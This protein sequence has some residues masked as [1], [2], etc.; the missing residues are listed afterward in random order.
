MFKKQGWHLLSL[1][2]SLVILSLLVDDQLLFGQ[3]W[4]I[5]TGTWFWVAVAVPIVH[6]IVVP[7][8]WRAE[9]YHRWMTKTFGENGF[10]IYKII[11]TI[12]FVGRPLSIILVGIANKNTLPMNPVIAYVVAFLFFLPAA[13]GMFSVI[14][15]FGIDRAYGIDHFEPETYR[16]KP[17]VKQGMFKHTDNVMYKYIFLVLW[18]LALV[19][20]SRAALL[21][22][23]FN[24]L[25][26]WVH[27]Y[28]TELP[29]MQVIYTERSE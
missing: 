4:G 3:L 20:L 2:V 7:L 5:S 22:A 1:V 25:Y 16:N 19:F 15:Y 18:S 13:Y 24:H 29:D 23:I 28:F 27:F 14:K 6:Q 9:L 8:V 17:F 12:L 10:L 21:V 26:I 11:F